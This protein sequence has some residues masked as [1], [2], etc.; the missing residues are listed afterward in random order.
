M[1]QTIT[2]PWRKQK[3]HRD[4]SIKEINGILYAR[5]QYQ[6]ELTGKRKEKLRRAKNRKHAN[7][8][9]KEMR[10]E[11]S[12]GGQLALESDQLSIRQ[13][14][15]KYERLKL[16]P[17]TY[18]NGIK[19]SGR[20][21]VGPA[22]SALRN[23]VTRLGDRKV[24]SLRPSDIETYKVQRLAE[25]VEIQVSVP[26]KRGRKEKSTA[27]NR[28]L[29]RPRKIASV[30]RELELLRALLNFAKGEGIVH[31]TPFERGTKLI[32]SAAEVQRDRVLSKDEEA[33]LVAEC[34][35]RR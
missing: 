26:A 16:V 13:L 12:H 2:E 31:S 34:V 5:V 27:A 11:L 29:L 35:G 18:Q 10:T 15:E 22:L 23:L 20:R 14:A 6:D 33:R 25:P 1:A 8:L 3:R 19:V 32:S 17:A 28:V 24:K 7:E 21:S 9:I 4:G 30:N